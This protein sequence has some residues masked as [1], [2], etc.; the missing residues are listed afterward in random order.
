MMLLSIRTV[1]AVA[2][3]LSFFTVAAGARADDVL[4]QVDESVNKWKTLDYKYTVTTKDSDDNKS[5]LRLR[6]RMRQH[7]GVNQQLVHITEPADMKGTKVLT[8]SPTEM[9]IYLPQ[10]K[11]IRRIASHVTEQ[12]FLGTTLSNKDLTLTRY[13]EYY[14]SSTKSEDDSEMELVL[15]P[16]DDTAP[17]PKLEMIVNKE[18]LVPSKIRYFNE[19]G[20]QVKEERRSAYRCEDGCCTPMTMVMTDLISGKT[21]TLRLTKWKINPKI[22]DEIFSKRSLK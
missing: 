16:K 8:L 20:K 12:G 15:T 3:A 14:T 21:S 19:E 13:S 5:T 17:Y 9:Y 1:A 7:E 11:K 22:K 6:M 18:R 4:V 10:Y 2:V